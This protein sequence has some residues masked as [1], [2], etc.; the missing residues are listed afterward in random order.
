MPTTV[1]PE[2]VEALFEQFLTLSHED[3]VDDRLSVG[4]EDPQRLERYAQR[5]MLLERL[6][7]A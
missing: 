1:T 7:R 3:E 4:F 6:E 2:D 5:T